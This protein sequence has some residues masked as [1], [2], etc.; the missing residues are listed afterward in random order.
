MWR[1]S[2]WLLSGVALLTVVEIGQPARAQVAVEPREEQPA[3][4]QPTLTITGELL[5]QWAF[6][7]RGADGARER[8]ESILASRI[9]WADQMYGLT[10]KQ[11]QKLSV[12]GRGDIKRHFDRAREKMATIGHGRVDRWQARA[13][14]QELHL[15][16]NP[17]SDPF[18]QGSMLAKTLS[19]TLTSEQ[20]ARGEGKDRLAAYRLRVQWVIFPLDQQLRL[21]REQHRRFVAAIVEGTRPLER[22]GELEDDAILLQASWLPEHTLKPIFNDAQWCLLKERFNQAKQQ[23][24]FL[25]EQGYLHEGPTITRPAV[26]EQGVRRT[27]TAAWRRLDRAGPQGTDG[28]G[29]RPGAGAPR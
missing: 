19:K 2:G 11:K 20:R 4:P 25:H 13:I 8:L 28:P 12:A 17:N 21:N 29:S 18:G 15:Q 24:R 6:G 5:E 9:K 1:I 7:P 26:P 22:Y 23:Q 3:Q 27:A 16:A 14:I 10:S